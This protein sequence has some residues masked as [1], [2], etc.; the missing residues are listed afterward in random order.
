ML[1]DK[2]GSPNSLPNWPPEG[3]LV[4]ADMVAHCAL[5]DMSGSF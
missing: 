1:P 3:K 5:I 2:Y 4:G